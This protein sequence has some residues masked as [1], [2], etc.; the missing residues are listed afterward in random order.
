MDDDGYVF[1]VDRIKDMIVSGGENVYSAEVESAVAPASGGGPACAVIGVPDAEWGE[2]VHAVVILVPGA[3][4]TVEELR[5]HCRSQIAG[6]KARA[7][8]TSSRRSPSRAPARSSSASCARATS[9][10]STAPA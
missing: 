2:R 9:D 5:E 4:L 1:I 8:S 3:D 6:Y 7:V 10:L